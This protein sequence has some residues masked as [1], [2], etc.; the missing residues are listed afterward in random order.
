MQ[1]SSQAARL[2]EVGTLS[3]RPATGTA[4]LLLAL[5]ETASRAGTS[6]VNQAVVS[7]IRKRDSKVA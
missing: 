7:S 1:T 3:C 6:N 2:C 5:H 4:A